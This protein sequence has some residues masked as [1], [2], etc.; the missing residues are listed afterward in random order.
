VALEKV[1]QALISGKAARQAG[2]TVEE[3]D[4]VKSLM[5][6]LKPV[7]YAANVADS[8]L[9]TGNE[10]SRKLTEF[11]KSEGSIVVIVSA[12]VTDPLWIINPSS[13]CNTV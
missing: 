13:I 2:L 10:L 11:A 1:N 3:L 4:L 9:A 7:I 6:T 12:Q 5:L 8:D